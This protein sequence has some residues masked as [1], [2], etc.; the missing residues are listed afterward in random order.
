MTA[1]DKFWLAVGGFVVIIPA[2]FALVAVLSY[3]DLI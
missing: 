2:L 1:A 3:F